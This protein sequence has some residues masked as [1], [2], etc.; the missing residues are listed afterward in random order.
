MTTLGVA[1]LGWPTR[2]PTLEGDGVRLRPWVP[3]DIDGVTAACQDPEIQRWT[4]VPVPYLREHAVQFV[5]SDA[6]ERWA[7]RSGALFCVAAPD[8][9]VLGS[10]AL[11]SVDPHRR[12][13]E[14]GYWVAAE[15][16]GAGVARRAAAA[17]VAWAMG[18]GGMRRLEF[19]VAPGNRPSRAVVEALGCRQE[20]ALRRSGP[21]HG[22]GDDL[23]L[24]S[25]TS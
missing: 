19:H 2:P 15:E 5:G 22:I 20:G 1:S 21:T 17:I 11:V 13:A 10:C 25:L 12:V 8:D 18:D 3:A 4:T 24:Y 9:R 6:P 23:R 16:R 14:V 7:D